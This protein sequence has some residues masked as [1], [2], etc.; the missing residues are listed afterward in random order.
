MDTTEVLWWRVVKAGDHWGQ[1]R[2]WGTPPGLLRDALSLSLITV[3]NAK[4]LL[5]FSV[6]SLF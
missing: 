6:I 5:F 1:S 3:E 4:N 2:T